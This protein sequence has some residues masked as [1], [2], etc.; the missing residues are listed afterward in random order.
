M[1]RIKCTFFVILI[2]SLGIA[3]CSAQTFSPTQV[4]EPSA[5]GSG[6]SLP[7]NEAEVPRVSVEEA[8]AAFDSG[9]AII[10]D[11]RNAAAYAESHVAGAIHIELGEVEIHPNDLDLDKNQWIITYCT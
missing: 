2:F 4:G 5:A 7:R 11:V 6:T 9:E 1:N 10:V 3:A 8:R